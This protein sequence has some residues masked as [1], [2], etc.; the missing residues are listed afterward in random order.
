MSKTTRR[1]VEAK[2]SL[3]CICIIVAVVQIVDIMDA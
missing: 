3:V 2:S 1:D